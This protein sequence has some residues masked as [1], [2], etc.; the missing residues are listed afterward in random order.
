MSCDRP[1]RSDL[2]HTIQNACVLG[3]ELI[4]PRLLCDSIA[5]IGLKEPYTVTSSVSVGECVSTMRERCMGSVLIVDRVGRIEGIF[6]ERDCLIKVLGLEGDL[7]VPVSRYMTAH[8]IC[9][10]PEASL[11]F[12]LNLMSNGG[13]RHVPIVDQDNIPIGIVSIKDVVDYIVKKMLRAVNE[14]VE[15][16]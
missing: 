10:R 7:S 12:V 13:F 16:C 15:G 5:S 2:L 11:A 8:P 9:E 4:S 6:T 1:E 3:I 14:A